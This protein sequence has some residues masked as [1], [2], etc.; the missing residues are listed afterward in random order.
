MHLLPATLVAGAEGAE[1]ER[2]GGCLARVT[3]RNPYTQM[4]L[5]LV[6]ST[7][8][9]LPLLTEEI[10]GAV[11]ACIQEQCTTLKA[12]A[13]AIGGIADHVHLLVRFPTSVT[14]GTLVKQVKGASS[15][16]VTH[17]L[18]QGEGFRWQGAYGAF[19]LSKSLVPRV[20]SYIARQAE[21]HRDGTLY[22]ELEKDGE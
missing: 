2:L 11:Y 8:E 10:R 21:H 16:L 13:V 7:R 4:Y 22:P 12:E 18:G 19:T 3:M 1:K 9:R 20:Q 6:W 14:V 15:H 17:R 5:H